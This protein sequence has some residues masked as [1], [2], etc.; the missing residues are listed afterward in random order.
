MVAPGF[1]LNL[2]LAFDA[3][4]TEGSVTRAAQRIGVTQPAISNSLRRL[5][6][7]SG[8]ELF[9][10]IGQKMTPTPRAMQIAENIRDA[11]LLIEQAMTPSSFEPQHTSFTFRLAMPDYI[12]FL[13]LPILQRKLSTL[14][15]DV[16]LRTVPLDPINQLSVLNALAQGKIDI[17]ID[18][19]LEIPRPFVSNLLF[20]GARS[21]IARIDHPRVHGTIDLE[22]FLD[23][24]HLVVSTET[25]EQDPVDKW[26]AAR[27]HRR[28]IAITVTHYLTTPMIIASTDL[29]AIVPA[30][31]ARSSASMVPLQVMDSPI[32]P[33][34]YEVAMIWHPRTSCSA[35][36]QWFRDIVVESVATLRESDHDIGPGF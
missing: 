27:G 6:Q 4:M 15:P 13:L 30:Q 22:E 10:R 19:F 24:S 2:L 17:G 33:P 23:E 8:D 29:I 32:Q 21:C 1:N 18:R 5:R 7:V 3:L 11:F 28:R 20:T 36:H 26:L 25:E 34:P 16:E 12:Q 35:P 9:T 14:A 31:L